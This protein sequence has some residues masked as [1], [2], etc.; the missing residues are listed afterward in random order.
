M[1][2]EL[3]RRALKRV[4][5]RGAGAIR[6]RCYLGSEED[7]EVVVEVE[8]LLPESDFVSGLLSDLESDFVSVFDPSAELLSPGLEVPEDLPFA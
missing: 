6:H 1:W 2:F 7:E 8:E 5:Y 4:F 3:E